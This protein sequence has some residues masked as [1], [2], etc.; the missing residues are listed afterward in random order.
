MTDGVHFWGKI[1]LS[2]FVL[3]RNFLLILDQ[4]RIANSKYDSFHPLF[5]FQYAAFENLFIICVLKINHSHSAT[6]IKSKDFW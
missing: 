3:F 2:F 4:A 1:I 5:G 6:L